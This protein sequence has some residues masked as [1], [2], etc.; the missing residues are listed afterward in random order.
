MKKFT[1]QHIYARRGVQLL[2]LSALTVC[3]WSTRYP[4]DSFMNPQWF[5]QADPLVMFCTAIAERVLLPGM[6][7]A[8]ILLGLTFVFGRFFCG[9]LCP[10]GTVIDGWAYLRKRVKAYRPSRTGPG[11]GRF[12]KYAI[13]LACVVAALFG[14]QAAWPLDP[15]TIFVRTFS[16]NAHPAFNRAMDSAFAFI[17][18]RVPFDPLERFYY[19]LKDSL[20]EVNVPVFPHSGAILAV[21]V[22][23]LVLVSLRRRF[24]CRYVCPLGGMLAAA[25]LLSPFKRRAVSCGGGCSVCRKI[26]RMNAINDDG[27]YEK[28][29]CIL[30]MDCVSFCPGTTVFSFSEPRPAAAPAAKTDGAGMT[31]AQFIA[32]AS[33]SVAGLAG[34]KKALPG[35]ESSAAVLRPPAALPEAE[36]V[37]RCIRC[38]NCMKVCLTNVLQPAVLESGLAGVWTPRLAPEI[39]Y[40]EHDCTLCGSVCPTGAIPKLSVDEK[41]ETRIGLAEIDER[42]CLPWAKGEECL[43][44]EEHCPVPEKAITTVERR[45][46][47]GK[48]IKYPSV[49]PSR[50]VGCAICE[51]KCPVRP[52]A[53]RVH[54]L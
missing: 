20:L 25:A 29:E 8:A 13:A 33:G 41:R 34:C 5:F 45:T 18:S 7:L 28:E 30:C 3:L 24:W 1:K 54:P 21:F 36:F 22:V 11:R 19:T 43:V 42:V 47:A 38:G 27:T 48:M 39:G 44:C 17:L 35:A 2:V 46:N 4:L 26:C 31:R 10:L 16:F 6:L 52:R 32:L 14:V 40:C 12:V 9:W 53:V 15:L 51:F 49:D 37:Q 23:I 50:C